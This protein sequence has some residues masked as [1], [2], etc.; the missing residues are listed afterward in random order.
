MG[1]NPKP[2]PLPAA[3]M[4]AM[5][6]LSTP[7]P[8]TP[9]TTPVEPVMAPP[10]LQAE[11]EGATLRQL[12]ELAGW[13]FDVPMVRVV[14]AESATDLRCLAHTDHGVAA[15]QA[16]GSGMDELAMALVRERGYAVVTD[17][18]AHP[19]MQ[20]HPWVVGEPHLR[21][22][23]AVAL[24]GADGLPVGVFCILDTQV[25]S[26][27]DREAR[28]LTT[29][30]NLA[31]DHLALRATAHR[32]A[33]MHAE[34][35]QRHGWMLESAS[36]DPLTQVANRRALM[37]FLD[38]TLALAR[39]EGHPVSVLL[40]DI[41]GFKDINQQ[42]GDTVGDRVL[43]EVASR[44]AGCMR[45]SELVGRMSG[46]EFMAVLY[47]CAAEQAGLAA[48]RYMAAATAQPVVLAAAGGLTVS[49][50][51]VSG[52]STVQSDQQRTSDELYRLAAAALD[53]AKTRNR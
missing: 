4:P 47:P 23:A 2:T 12:A 18:Q 32:V 46:D 51:M 25:R 7:T 35:E 34:L 16:D 29:L 3:T 21:F 48:T 30:A 17:A 26:L 6:A 45:G 15:E 49:V 24:A 5:N 10:W 31:M 33:L 53:A 1:D 9:L 14:R 8:A 11:P 43:L 27:S 37:A 20:G 36:Q 19:A 39:R 28:M 13:A 44:L 22:V 38:K 40:L 42:L 50:R 52:V 41:Q